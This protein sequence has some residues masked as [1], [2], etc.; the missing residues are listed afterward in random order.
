MLRPPVALPEDLHPHG[1][2]LLPVTP[3]TGDPTPSERHTCR[4][5]NEHRNKFLK[6]KDLKESRNVCGLLHFPSTHGLLIEDFE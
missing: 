2:S 1:S 3:V 5:N 6:K 4:Q